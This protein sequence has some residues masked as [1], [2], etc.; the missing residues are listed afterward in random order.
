MVRLKL[1]KTLLSQILD[2][3]SGLAASSLDYQDINDYINNDDVVNAANALLSQPSLSDKLHPCLLSIKRYSTNPMALSQNILTVFKK[4]VLF[5][6]WCNRK[7]YERSF[8]FCSP[9]L[10][11]MDA[12]YL[13]KQTVGSEYEQQLWMYLERLC[14]KKSNLQ[15]VLKAIVQQKRGTYVLAYDKTA[16]GYTTHAIVNNEELC[17]YAFSASLHEKTPVDY[18]KL[19]EFD[20]S[21]V[22]L[23]VFNYNKAVIYQQ[24]YDI[25]DVINDW[26]HSKDI[27]TAFLRMYQIVEFLVYRQQMSDIIRISSIKQSFLREVKN[28]NKSFDQ[29]ERST[30]IEN[31]PTVFGVLTASDVNL[32]KAEPFIM[33]YYGKN[34]KGDHAYLHKGLNKNEK[35]TGIAR[36]IYDTR[37]S[38]V[39]N[40]EAEFHISYN[41]Y[42]EYKVMLPLLKEVHG[43][44]ADKIWTQMNTPGSCISYENN[45]FIDLF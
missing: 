15:I 37:C 5:E 25:Y 35:T 13:Y 11:V 27:L 9:S 30:M 29:G 2:V 21:S 28:L 19:L 33:K 22:N 31:I 8:C 34:K 39:H 36:F 42:E 38:I 45:R 26:L 4:M 17:S 3:Y 20:P 6:K 32:D 43:Q 12:D 7:K 16:L 40:K 18:H 23:N 41:N 14:V 44:L 10:F 1:Y 24:Y